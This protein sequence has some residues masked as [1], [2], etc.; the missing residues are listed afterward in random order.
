VTAVLVGAVVLTACAGPAPPGVVLAAG[1]AARAEVDPGAD[2]AT[3][4]AGTRALGHQLAVDLAPQSDS[5]NLVLSP[6]SIATAFAMLRQGADGRTAEQIDDVM[7]YPEDSGAAYNALLQ[8]WDRRSGTAGAP[9]LEVACS[10]WV[11]HGLPM[12][13]GFLDAMSSQF[14]TG[15][16]QVDFADPATLEAINAWASEHTHGRVPRAF[17][18]LPPETVA[19][20]LNAVHLKAAWQQPFPEALT[21]DRLFLTAA[22]EEVVVPMMRSERAQS[23]VAVGE[24]WTA[25]RLGVRGGPM[26]MWVLVPDERGADPLPLLDPRVLEDAERTAQETVVDLSLPR[27]DLGT[28]TS[29]VESLQALGVTDAFDDD[30]D[31]SRMSTEDLVVD[32]M[33]HTANITVDEAGFEAAAV[34]GLAMV[35]SAPP[36]PEVVVRADHP[37][38]WVITDGTGA[39]LFE[40]VVGDPSESRD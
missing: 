25:V 4:A 7:G 29:L 1:D 14:G 38:A 22:G 19:A 10:L 8:E 34:T 23:A 11:Q 24:G 39:A 28:S 6:A 32:Q 30:A 27:W 21:G 33:Q 20:L 13:N 2:T 26:A 16:Q 9:V 31:L 15:V 37:F 17:A 35:V 40:G 36:P 3:A 5:G 12:E 18:E